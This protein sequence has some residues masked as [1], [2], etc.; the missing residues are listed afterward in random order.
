MAEPAW[1]VVILVLGEDRVT[2]VLGPYDSPQAASAASQTVRL[3]EADT[4]VTREAVVRE[5][6]RKDVY[7]QHGGGTWR[8]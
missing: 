2:S 6:R 3:G 5:I 1:V 4:G 8:E 7:D